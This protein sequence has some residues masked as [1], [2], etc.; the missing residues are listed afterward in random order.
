MYALHLDSASCNLSTL[1]RLDDV[2]FVEIPQSSILIGYVS[3][4]KLLHFP[5]SKRMQAS[6]MSWLGAHPDFCSSRGATAQLLVW[7]SERQSLTV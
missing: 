5:Q 4:D 3:G 7:H 1:S 2:D 6:L